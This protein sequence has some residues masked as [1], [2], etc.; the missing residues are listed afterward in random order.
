[1]A[2]YF[3]PASLQS[4]VIMTRGGLDQ[5]RPVVEALRDNLPSGLAIARITVMW[6]HKAVW[7]EV[8]PGYFIALKLVL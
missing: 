5:Y 4:I 2:R 3:L 8:G 1:M 7:A 6:A